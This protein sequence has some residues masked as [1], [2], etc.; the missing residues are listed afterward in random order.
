[1]HLNDI[2]IQSGC[3]L[4]EDTAG[5]VRRSTG[6]L[7]QQVDSLPAEGDQI[8]GLQRG[9]FQYVPEETAARPGGHRAGDRRNCR[10]ARAGRR[11]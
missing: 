7:P 8:A 9:Q 5:G 3:R 11:R 2:P 4:R 6:H 10:A 1:M